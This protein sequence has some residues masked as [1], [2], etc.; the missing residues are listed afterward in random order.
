MSQA[1]QIQNVKTQYD[2]TVTHN[3]RTCSCEVGNLN[4]LGKNA[5]RYSMCD[6]CSEKLFVHR[7]K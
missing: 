4:I 6:T 7:F 3:L 1:I 2:Q 5:L